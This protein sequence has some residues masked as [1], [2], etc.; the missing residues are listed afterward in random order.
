MHI[1]HDIH[2]L[3]LDNKRFFRHIMVFHTEH[4]RIYEICL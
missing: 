4:L 3:H 1:I 2:V